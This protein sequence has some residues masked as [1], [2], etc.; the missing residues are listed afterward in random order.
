MVKTNK[1]LTGVI[2]GA[3]IGAV[4]GLL[5]APKA[6]RETRKL[7]RERAAGLGEKAGGR[8]GNLFGKGRAQ[9]EAK[10]SAGRDGHS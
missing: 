2:A 6:G 1:F 9:E 10:A 7:L 3:V 4:A 5:L 8:F